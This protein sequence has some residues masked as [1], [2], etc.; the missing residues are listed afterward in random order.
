MYAYK[1]IANIYI[2]L[3]RYDTAIISFK[4]LLALAWTVKS[5]ECEYAAYEGLQ[6]A[7]LYKGLIDKV[8]FYNT[9]ATKGE[10]ESHDS[11]LY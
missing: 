5:R 4:Y 11:K 7:Y 8:E 9:G 10:Y 6:R 2:Q 3:E 1:Q